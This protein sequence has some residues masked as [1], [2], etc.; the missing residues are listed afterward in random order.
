MAPSRYLCDSETQG[1]PGE[2]AG[3]PYPVERVW[4]LAAHLPVLDHQPALCALRHAITLSV[5]QPPRL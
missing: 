2:D 3:Q 5:P 4:Q 1:E